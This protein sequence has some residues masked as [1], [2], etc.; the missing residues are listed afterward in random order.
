MAR[1][2]IHKVMLVLFYLISCKR[3]LGLVNLSVMFALMCSVLYLY[4]YSCVTELSDV[5]FRLL[6]NSCTK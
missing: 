4:C 6:E 3:S 2:N 1:S 5:A